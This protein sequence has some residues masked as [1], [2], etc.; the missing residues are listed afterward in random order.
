MSIP[1]TLDDFALILGYPRTPLLNLG[2][3][4]GNQNVNPDGSSA[5]P[6]NRLTRLQ[7]LYAEILDIEAKLS[8]ARTNSMAVNLG[9]LSLNY[10]QHID[11]LKLTGHQKLEEMG[12]ILNLPIYFDRFY[13]VYP[14]G[15]SFYSNYGRRISSSSPYS[16]LSLI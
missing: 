2:L 11:E 9:S 8:D 10:Q 16:Y 4:L 13:G 5:I 3:A 12:A 15:D 6:S 7:A 1:T 14:Q